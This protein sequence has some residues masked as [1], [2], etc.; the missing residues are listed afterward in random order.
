[1]SHWKQ[2]FTAPLKRNQ[3][4]FSQIELMIIQGIV[5]KVILPGSPMPSTRELAQFLKVHPRTVRKTYERLIAKGWLY[6]EDR[7]GTFVAQKTERSWDN[8]SKPVKESY[9]S[10][11][12]LD[13]PE[14][15]LPSIRQLARSYRTFFNRAARHNFLPYSEVAGHTPLYNALLN[16][17]YFERGIKVERDQICRVY[18][19]RTPFYI[20]IQ[21]LLQKKPG[22]AIMG[23]PGISDVWNLFQI[24]GADP[25]AI[26][27]DKNGLDIDKLKKYCQD[28][29][30]RIV[31]VS[32]RNH[33]PTTATLSDERRRGLIQLSQQYNFT[34][35]ETDFD[36]ELDYGTEPY[37]PLIAEYPNAPIIHITSLSKMMPSLHLTG[38]MIAS[39][40]FIHNVQKRIGHEHNLLFEQ[41]LHELLED[42]HLQLCRQKAM[43]VYKN[44]FHKAFQRIQSYSDR[45]ECIYPRSGLSL[46]L[47]FKSVLWL[48]KRIKALDVDGVKIIPLNRYTISAPSQ[49]GLRINLG[50]A[51]TP[52]VNKLMTGLYDTRT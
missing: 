51:K 38:I 1:M 52:D 32:P 20:S 47:S 6:A 5:E 10:D 25:L 42:G 44:R 3:V 45:H 33:I 14:L 12:T 40:Q 34:I 16:E 48:K 37:Q 15:S 24:A 4:L 11:L 2:I 8:T 7:K 18:G 49:K 23:N 21:M 31:Y 41:T 27:V 39:K 29:P 28:Y 36:H 9:S 19:F 46:W 17:L 50:Y 43:R 26:P 30:I 22:R 35:I 13:F